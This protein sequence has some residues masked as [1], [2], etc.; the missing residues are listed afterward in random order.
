[1]I[2]AAQRAQLSEFLKSRRARLS[3]SEVGLPEPG[4]RRRPGLRREDVAAIAKVS[5]TWYSWLE[6]GRDVQASAKM[7]D[8]LAKG[9]R[10]SA[11][12]RAYLF[13][14]AQPRPVPPLP[15]R[16]AAVDPTIQRMLDALMIPALV[17]TTRWD[18]LAWNR[19][20]AEVHRDYAAMDQTERNLLKLLLTSPQYQADPR[21]YD[22]IAHRVVAKLRLDYSQSGCDPIFEPLIAEMSA[23]SPKFRALWHTP[24]IVSRSYGKQVVT[25]PRLGRIGLEHTSYVIEGEPDLRLIL[26]APAD[27]DSADKIGLLAGRLPAPTLEGYKN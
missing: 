2:G 5:I 23:I 19:L 8:N 15:V 6:Q 1:M 7:L 10:L 13:A 26:F 3:P 14:L 27:R 21:E 24:E 4:R 9:L 16:A 20:V 17:M 25:H 18:V 22:E 11:D 12:D